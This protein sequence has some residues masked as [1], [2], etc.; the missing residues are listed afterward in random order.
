MRALRFGWTAAIPLVALLLTVAVPAGAQDFEVAPPRFFLDRVE[1]GGGGARMRCTEN[2]TSNEDITDL[3]SYGVRLERYLS[4]LLRIGVDGG[5]IE[6]T[7][8]DR[9]VLGSGTM[10]AV[11]FVVDNTDL[12]YGG[13]LNF[14]VPTG[15]PFFNGMARLGPEDD[16]HLSASYA[17][18]LPN[19]SSDDVEVG[20]GTRAFDEGEIWLGASMPISRDVVTFKTMVKLRPVPLLEL[21]VTGRLGKTRA[22]RLEGGSLSL[23][24]R[25]P[26]PP[27]RWPHGGLARLLAPDPGRLQYIGAGAITGAI[28]GVLTAGVADQRPCGQAAF[29]TAVYGVVVGGL[30]GAVFGNA[31]W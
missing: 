21:T 29:K 19:F 24:Y 1:I 2:G 30:L 27:Q 6:R 28:G 10:G 25:N 26:E 22:G 12:A 4:P 13:G 15:F 9:P 31:M 23:A 17:R 16:L 5:H 18:S 11:Y 3:A 8:S 20:M 14:N 7:G